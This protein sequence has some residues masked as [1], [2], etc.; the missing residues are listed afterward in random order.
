MTKA[1]KAKPS[2]TKKP[3]TRRVKRTEQKKEKISEPVPPVEENK[4]SEQTPVIS[5]RESKK[6][7]KTQNCELIIALFDETVELVE[8]EIQNIRENPKTTKGVKFLRSLNKRLKNLRTRTYKVM[9]CKKKK[10]HNTKNS[11][12]LKPVN[13]SEDM[14]KFT[15]WD[16]KDLRSRVEVTKYICNYI[17]EHD[18]QNPEDRRQIRPDSKLQKLLGYNP[19][20]EKKPL[21]Y[22]SLQ[23]H[24]K[25]HFP[26]S[27]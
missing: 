16:T 24:L 5:T 20:K 21:M 25:K 27:R 1:M 22:Y 3:R 26:L 2:S 9:K 7:S 10:G 12:F 17:K 18:L 19:K 11:G 4:H 6:R 8:Q 15:G 23:T 14:A 13:I